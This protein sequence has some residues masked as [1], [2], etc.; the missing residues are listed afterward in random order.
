MKFQIT[1][2]GSPGPNWTWEETTGLDGLVSTNV[3]VSPGPMNGPKARIT[4]AWIIEASYRE[5]CKRYST[6]EG[7]LE[8]ATVVTA[9]AAGVT[10]P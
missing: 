5:T 6:G 4:G 3:N 1:Y 10:V 2:S 9:T 8:Y 7:C